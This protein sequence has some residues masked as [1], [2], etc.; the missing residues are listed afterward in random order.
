MQLRL[1]CKSCYGTPCRARARCWQA[2]SPLLAIW[3]VN[4]PLICR[5]TE[6]ELGWVTTKLLEEALG[7]VTAKVTASPAAALAWSG[8]PRFELAGMTLGQASLDW[9][10]L[11][12]PG[13]HAQRWQWLQGDAAGGTHEQGVA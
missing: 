3:V 12:L 6:S 7:R 10:C 13:Q 9:H 4:Q 2:V 1:A 8:R 11:Q 5:C